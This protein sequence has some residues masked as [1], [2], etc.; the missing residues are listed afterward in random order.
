MASN[1]T[2][3]VEIYGNT[4]KFEN[5][6]K[7]VNTA[8][9]GLRGEAK[10][11]RE[12]LKLDPTNTGKM[13]QLQKNLQTQLGLSRDKAT[14]LKEE[15]ATVDKSTPAGQ[16]KWLQLTRDL[17]TAETQANRLESE[18]KQVEGAIKSGSWNIDAKMDTKGVNSGIDG[19]KSRFSGLREIAVGV[20]RQIGA[21]AVS[22]VGNGLKGWVSDAMDTQKA[23]ISLNNTMKFKGNGQEFDYVSKSMQNLAKDTNAN[24]EDTLKLSTT[25]IGLGD[26][27]KSAVSKTEALVKANQAFGGTGE[28]LKGVVQAYGQM[29]ASGK[30]TAENINQLT[31][32]N[33]ALGS[34]LKSTVMEMNPALKQYGSFAEASENGA[35]SVEMLDKA[36]QQLGK[37]G[38]GGVT[39]IS[40]AWD[41][42]NETLSLALLPTLDALT[43][44]ISALIDKMAGWGE[45]AGKTIT[46]VIKYFQDLFQKLQEN[47]TTLAFL[48]AWDN[49]KSAFDS[50]VSIIGNVINSFLGINTE[51]TKNKTSI[52]NV[53]KSIA[54]F[55]GKFSEVTKK[56][57]DFLKKIS[58]SKRAMDTLK[59]TLVVLASAF[60]ALK[61]IDGIVKAIELYNKIVKIGTAIQGAFN[62]VM[63]INPFVALGI[64]IVAIVAGLVYFFTQTETGK[65]VWQS[66][67]DFLSQSIEAIKQFFTGLGTW[68][69]E[70]WTSTVE[71][72]KTIWNG[73]TEFFS[74]LWN[75]IVTIIT[76]VFATIASA[77]TGAYN[78]FVTT[79]QP[80]ISFYQ[81]IFNLIGSIINV[82]F[83]LILAIV[84]GAYQLVIG[85][86]KGLSGFFGGIFN[87][88]SSVVSSVFG[89]IGSFASSA[90]GV[91]R[92]IWSAVSGFFSGIFNSVR[93]VVSGVFSA[94]GGFAS[95]AWSRI[96]GVFSGVSGFFSGVFSG[97]TSAV[98]GA[99]S[100]FG[101]FASN[102]YNA[103]TGVFNG[104]GGFFSGIFGGIKNTIDSVLGG[105]TNTINNISGAINGIAGKLGGLFKGSM[106]VGLTDVNLSSS[107]YGLSTNSVSSDNRTYN[108]FNVQGGAG[109][110]V[111]N[112]ARAIRR[113]FDLGRA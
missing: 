43:P 33:T 40:D 65:K 93:G 80:L 104:I 73:I 79:F 10:N 35:V 107:G 94:I 31:D 90:W 84:R 59:G 8:M 74:G 61:V 23:M 56:I 4:T 67:V 13:A 15:L 87:A 28:Q 71:G 66:F 22:A 41:S 53:A 51:T 76:N 109:Q 52:D 82:A 45:S 108:T 96:S 30:V 32:N 18:I 92:S 7:G 103:I 89:A 111:S 39:T 70:L 37:A 24:T 46:N 72:T 29:S 86:W 99:F 25:F 68:F 57:S 106:V 11:L 54:I 81:S 100:A 101:S 17:G 112:L 36:M 12:A 88:V 48:E 77:V 62:A 26:T 20:F 21:S 1:A 27:A 78:W 105:V 91:V 16:K 98:S 102:A 50:I 14:K 6:L 42:F 97:A 3:E 55:A 49:I 38:G 95:N 44:I 19:M 85:A 47:G 75:G 58:E 5:S 83:Q 60:V 110:D 2:F 63:A 113:E 69:S 64:A 9:S 34:A